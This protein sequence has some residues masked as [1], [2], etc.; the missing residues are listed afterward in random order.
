MDAPDSELAPRF[1]PFFGM[2]CSSFLELVL[3]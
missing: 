3:C 1:A 2:V